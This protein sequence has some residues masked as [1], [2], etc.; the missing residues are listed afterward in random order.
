MKLTKHPKISP[1]PVETTKAANTSMTQAIIKFCSNV[2]KKQ[3]EEEIL[4]LEQPVLL[5]DLVSDWP[6]VKSVRQDSTSIISYLTQFD[7]GQ[8]AYTVVGQPDI[9][10]RFFYGDKLKGV[11]FQRTQTTVTKVLQ[12]LVELA[13]LSKPHAI[14]MQAASVQ[15]VLP[16]LIQQMPMPILPNDI[17]PTLWMGNKAVVAPHYDTSDNVACVIAGKRNF[18][19]FPPEQIKN[20]YIGPS[21]DAPGGVPISMVDLRNPDFVKYPKFA[22]A[23]K[24]AIQVTLQPGDAIYIPSPWW[25]AVESLSPINLLVNYWW[26]DSSNMLLSPNQSM[27]HSMLSVANLNSKKKQAWR[28]FFD[29]LVFHTHGDP[30][31]HLPADLQDIVTSLSEEQNQ[32]VFEFLKRSL[33]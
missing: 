5:K 7:S 3:F 32:R 22:E 17:A 15:D 16:N 26:N 12:H 21:L 24:S 2:D 9:E 27:M 4:P 6:V 20:L 18:T 29:Y 8:P 25:H 19:L 30:A 28:H 10:G 14:A 11:N 1:K 33:N 31:A 23:M 13:N